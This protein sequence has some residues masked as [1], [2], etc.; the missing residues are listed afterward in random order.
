[1]FLLYNLLRLAKNKEPFSILPQ[2]YPRLITM[3]G[4]FDFVVLLLLSEGSSM[5]VLLPDKTVLE[6]YLTENIPY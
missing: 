1:M 6:S 4:K 2:H 3:I 5:R